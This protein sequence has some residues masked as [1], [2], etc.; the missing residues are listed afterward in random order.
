MVIYLKLL[1]IIYYSAMQMKKAKPLEKPQNF[2]NFFCCRLQID[3]ELFP[4]EEM[5]TFTEIIDYA[6]G[7]GKITT[8]NIYE[9]ST[10]EQH[11]Q[12]S[13]K[14]KQGWGSRRISFVFLSAKA[15]VLVKKFL[16]GNQWQDLRISEKEADGK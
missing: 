11:F 1:S 7:L 6:G 2:S 5:V 4:K 16:L 14:E 3:N 8:S 12:D 15:S 13:T 9:I 10:T